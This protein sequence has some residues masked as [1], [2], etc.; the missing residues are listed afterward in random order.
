MT[1]KNWV[2]Q[3]DRQSIAWLAS[4]LD[5][6]AVISYMGANYVAFAQGGFSYMGALFRARHPEHGDHV[7]LLCGVNCRAWGT[8]SGRAEMAHGDKANAGTR[9]PVPS[10]MAPWHQLC[11][12]MPI[13]NGWEFRH[14]P[15]LEKL[16]AEIQA[17][18]KKRADKVKA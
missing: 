13:T 9:D 4:W 8:S 10:V 11:V 14:S 16:I 2:E 3:A 1:K 7:V 6:G 15:P 18:E 12:W 5:D 17:A